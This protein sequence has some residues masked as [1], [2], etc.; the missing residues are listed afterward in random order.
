MVCRVF[1]YNSTCD[2][3]ESVHNSKNGWIL[4]TTISIDR[5]KTS[6]THYPQFLI[7]W[8]PDNIF[9]GKNIKLGKHGAI[10][11]ENTIANPHDGHLGRRARVYNGAR[12][13]G[14]EDCED[15]DTACDGIDGRSTQ[16][17]G[18]QEA[19]ETRTIRFK[20]T[21]SSETSPQPHPGWPLT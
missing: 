11:P 16:I 21:F 7:P 20:N 5:G 13:R 9:D 12:A 6:C 18:C 4:W 17:S 10:G 15:E 19:A 1:V 14:S 2:A 8:G 3:S